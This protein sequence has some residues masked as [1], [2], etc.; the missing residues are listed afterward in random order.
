MRALPARR[1]ASSALCAALLVGITG[2][3][4]MAADSARER[5]HAASP[6]ARRAG[7]DALLGQVRTIYGGELAPVA[8]LLNAVLKADNGRLTAAEARRLGDAA[9]AA[10]DKAAAEQAAKTP[11]TGVLLLAPPRRDTDSTVDADTDL[12][13]GTLDA[14]DDL[15][16]TVE[17]AVD[18]LLEA[19]TSSDDTEVAPSVDDLLAEL[20]D[21]IDDLLDDG[22]LLLPTSVSTSTPTPTPTTT[23]SSSSS[24]STTQETSVSVG[25][26]PEATPSA[27]VRLS[28]W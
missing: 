18:D 4:A 7:A 20:E 15:L 8:D 14:V 28:D 13:S 12:T 9:K 25:T 27:M 5:G 19:L 6:D 16:D 2:P 26:L 1:I 11:A 24:M 3:A 10:L 17:D 22:L 23:S 21:L